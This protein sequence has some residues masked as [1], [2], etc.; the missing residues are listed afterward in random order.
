MKHNR[1]LLIS[2]SLVLIFEFGARLLFPAQET[3]SRGL[4][5]LRLLFDCG[6]LLGVVGLS[7]Q[8]LK[9]TSRPIDVMGPWM[10]LPALG[11]LAALG[12]SSCD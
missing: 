9:S 8:I 4:S 11:L 1:I 7:V 3:E 10:A 5:L 12:L 2:C 6:M